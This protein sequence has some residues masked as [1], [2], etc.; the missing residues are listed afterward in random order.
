MVK[1]SITRIFLGFFF[2]CNNPHHME[3]KRRIPGAPACLQLKASPLL[4]IF[5][6]WRRREESMKPA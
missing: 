1:R 3:E 4:F 6:W 2:N 5:S